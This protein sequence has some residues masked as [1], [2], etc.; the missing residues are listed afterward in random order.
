MWSTRRN[1]KQASSGQNVTNARINHAQMRVFRRWRYG[2]RRPRASHQVRVLRDHLELPVVL[3]GPQRGNCVECSFLDIAVGSVRGAWKTKPHATEP[4]ASAAGTPRSR[5][6]AKIAVKIR[7]AVVGGE[8]IA[9]ASLPFQTAE[10]ATR[11][12]CRKISIRL[13]DHVRSQS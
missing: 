6:E 4:D 3:A 9:P 10:A 11:V 12:H 8:Q 1:R 5:E 7:Y 13:H 2:Q